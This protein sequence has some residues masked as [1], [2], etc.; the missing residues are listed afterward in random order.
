M[1]LQEVGLN[2]FFVVFY[3]FLKKVFYE[4]TL[5]I[6]HEKCGKYC[7]LEVLYSIHPQVIHILQK[8]KKTVKKNILSKQKRSSKKTHFL[9]KNLIFESFAKE[10]LYVHFVFFWESARTGSQMLNSQHT[11]LVLY[12]W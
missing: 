7:I 8:I 12:G 3:F 5:I 10:G 4:G 2:C 9:E 6:F 11:N 1:V